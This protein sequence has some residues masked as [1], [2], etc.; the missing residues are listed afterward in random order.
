[1]KTLRADLEQNGAGWCRALKSIFVPDAINAILWIRIYLWLEERGLPTFWSHRILLHLHGLEFARG[2]QIGPGLYLPH[3]RGVL[4]AESTI[5]GA[6]VAVY[7]NVRFLRKDERAP[8]IGDNV[9]IGDGAQFVGATSIGADS[10]VGAGA[11][12]TRSFPE[13]SVIAGNPAKL[14]RTL[15]VE[16]HN[17]EVVR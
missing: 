12:V 8:M 13:R 7:G 1:M 6:G 14:I 10:K 16:S 17:G 9:S 4:F 11:V 3:P 15:V 5:L 2:V